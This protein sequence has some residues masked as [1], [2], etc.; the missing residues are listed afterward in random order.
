MSA[1]LNGCIPQLQKA[2]LVHPS[3][4]RNAVKETWNP[5]AVD[6][7]KEKWHLSL[8]NC[9]LQKATH[10]CIH[11]KELSHMQTQCDPCWCYGIHAPLQN[12]SPV[13]RSGIISSLSVETGMLWRGRLDPRS[14]LSGGDK[15][16]YF[17]PGE[18]GSTSLEKTGVFMEREVGLQVYLSGGNWSIYEQIWKLGSRP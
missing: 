10:T 7:R 3:N 14:S 11:V 16:L 17:F 4:C 6:N 12:V 9:R 18:A 15:C 8:G 1:W 13:E 5:S 2:V